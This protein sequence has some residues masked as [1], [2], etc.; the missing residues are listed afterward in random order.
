MF[1]TIVLLLLAELVLGHMAILL[2]KGG[3]VSYLQF[4][5]VGIG[6]TYGLETSWTYLILLGLGLGYNLNVSKTDPTLWINEVSSM[7]QGVHLWAYLTHCLLQ[8][9]W[10]NTRKIEQNTYSDSWE[11]QVMRWSIYIVLIMLY[12]FA[13]TDIN[14]YSVVPAAFI[15]G[16]YFTEGSRDLGIQ[17]LDGLLIV[18]FGMSVAEAVVLDYGNNSFRVGV[19]IASTVVG[20]ILFILNVTGWYTQDPP[21][22][23]LVE[24]EV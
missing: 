8:N 10:N 17:I 7:V 22:T 18:F 24:K 21:S 16:A 6:I 9:K 19:S 12:D 13:T 1:A 23:T 3:I 5:V 20:F 4:L 15:V 2:H 11:P 14:L